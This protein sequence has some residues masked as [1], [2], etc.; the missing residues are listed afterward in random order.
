MKLQFLGSA[1]EVGRSCITINDTFLL[2]A[3]I[4]IGAEASEYP[5][6]FSEKDIKAVFLSHA[7]LDHTG[8]LPLLNHLGLRCVIYGTKMTKKITQILLHDSMHIEKLKTNGPAYTEEN[9]NN[10][11]SYFSYVNYNR[12]YLEKGIDMRYKFFDAGHIPGSSSILLDFEDDSG[13]RKKL[14]YTG[15]VNAVNTY[16]LDGLTYHRKNPE[17]KGVDVMITESTYGSRDHPLRADQEREFLEQIDHTLENN[18]SVLIPAF[19]VGRAQEILMMLDK[20]HLNAP[21]FLDGMAKSVTDLFVREGKFIKDEKLLKKALKRVEYIKDRNHRARAVQSQGIFVSTAGMIDGGPALDYLKYLYYDTKNAVLLTGFQG[22]GS[23]GQRLLNSRRAE[24]DGKSYD[25]RA[26]IRKYD[27][28]AHSGQKEL[29]EMIK[30]IRP[31][32]LV[33]N[34]GDPGEIQALAKK[35]EGMAGEVHMPVNGE[36]LRIN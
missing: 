34:H 6:D 25:V 3:G 11:L 16:L 23:N 5:L 14:F 8:A 26:F 7:H 21:I 12:D 10:V 32:N 36:A 31:K 4:K 13:K 28:S 29:I 9:I 24:I 20:K 19:S 15:D 18:G 35:V 1:Q 22:E 2:D 30:V 27:F 33:I 17:L